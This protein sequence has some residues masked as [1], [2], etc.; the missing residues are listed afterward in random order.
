M[1]E[2]EVFNRWIKLPASERKGKVDGSTGH[3]ILQR[4]KG[5]VKVLIG[6][7][8]IPLLILQEGLKGA[9]R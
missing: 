5:N 7:I 3:I 6:R 9:R 4:K 2:I 1:Y 8:S